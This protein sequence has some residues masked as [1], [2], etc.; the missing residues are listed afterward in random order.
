MPIDPHNE[1]LIRFSEGKQLP[2][3]PTYEMLYH[4][5]ATGIK[6]KTNGHRFFLETIQIGGTRYT[7]KQAF[8]RFNQKINAEEVRT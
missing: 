6:S 3:E 4:W 2:G 5:Y 7:S 1:V 8:D